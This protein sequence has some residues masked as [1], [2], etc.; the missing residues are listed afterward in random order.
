NWA[1]GVVAAFDLDVAGELTDE[2]ESGDDL[3]RPGL[4]Q[5]VE[6]FRRAYAR[7]RPILCLLVD[8]ADR[9]SRADSLETSALVAELRKLGLRY[10]VTA[11]R[12]FD[13]RDPMDKTLL[14]IEM[15]HKNHPFLKDLGRR[16]LNGT[17]D[18]A[19]LGFWSGRI[20]FGYKLVKM[21][22]DHP[23]GKRRS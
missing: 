1:H 23:A 10:I 16:V 2:G 6:L 17:I 20:P 15:E 12:I 14:Q 9:L 22:G 19:R 5:L 13:L 7:K 11:T 21:V 3:E 18:V 8:L 4:L